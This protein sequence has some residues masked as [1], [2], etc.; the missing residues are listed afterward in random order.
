MANR[1]FAQ[2]WFFFSFIAYGCDLQELGMLSSLYNWLKKIYF[3]ILLVNHKP[4]I[5]VYF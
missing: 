3:N 2:A 1:A 4:V 5:F